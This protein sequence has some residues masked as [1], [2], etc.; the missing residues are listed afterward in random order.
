MKGCK[1]GSAI[2]NM[3][4][5]QKELDNDAIIKML[6]DEQAKTIYLLISQKPR[7]ASELRKETNIP[8]TT[9]YRK[10]T[11]LLEKGLV[12]GMIQQR[13]HYTKILLYPII[14]SVV[15]NFSK[16]KGIKIY[17]KLVY[18]Q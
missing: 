9:L 18:E 6:G 5:Q 13:S 10:L 8:S 3:S 4:L 2:I 15:I 17:T 1:E 14:E 16:E 7:V 11:W 12:R